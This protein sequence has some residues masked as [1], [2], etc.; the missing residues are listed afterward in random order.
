MFAPI[1]IDD[2]LH[3]AWRPGAQNGFRLCRIPNIRQFGRGPIKAEFFAATKNADMAARHWN[4][5]C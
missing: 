3:C 4:D 5:P 2:D 1:N